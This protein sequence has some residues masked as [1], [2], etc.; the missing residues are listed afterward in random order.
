MSLTEDLAR[1]IQQEETL[2]FP[3]FDEALAWQIGCNL[4]D[5]ATENS[6]PLVID[7]RRFDRQ[8]F[9]AALPGSTTDNQ[10]WVRRKTNSVQRFLRSTYRLKHQLALENQ[11]ITQRYYLSPADYTCAGGGFPVIVQGA[12]VIGS[13]TVSGLPDRQDHQLIV[14]GLCLQLGHDPAA[15]ALSTE[16][17]F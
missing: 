2:Q 8:L 5:Q 13:I 10:E 1:L 7:V 15:L 12:G 11:D 9:F 4:Y 6:W 3:H 14:E 17:P 16:S